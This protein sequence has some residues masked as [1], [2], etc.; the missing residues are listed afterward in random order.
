MKLLRTLELPHTQQGANWIINNF[1][2][3]RYT[4]GHW[5]SYLEVIQELKDKGKEIQSYVNWF[6]SHH[7]AGA[8]EG[9]WAG[10]IYDLAEKKDLWLYMQPGTNGSDPNAEHG[11]K[12]R[13]WAYDGAPMINLSK[14]S[15]MDIALIG[16]FIQA[17]APSH[18]VMADQIWY[19][20]SDW[21][22][23]NGNVADLAHYDPLSYDKHQRELLDLVASTSPASDPEG[24][25]FVI[26]TNGA[27]TRYKQ[28]PRTYENLDWSRYDPIWNESLSSWLDSEGDALVLAGTLASD[29][30]RL[31]ISITR[32]ADSW[33]HLKN[34]Q[35]ADY[36]WEHS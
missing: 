25:K 14:L 24:R 9:S 21:M 16:Q 30:V 34:D 13:M 1:P 5:N 28:F 32:H 27:W 26:T 3:T 29:K 17:N 12:A 10:F 2:A 4:W 35:A 18:L 11:P 7:G 8:W 22:I 36:A 31:A 33:L 19:S 15:K 6:H 20:L 23:E